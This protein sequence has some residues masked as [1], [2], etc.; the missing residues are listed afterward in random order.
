MISELS[1][2]TAD[3]RALAVALAALALCAVF[4]DFGKALF[5]GVTGLSSDGPLVWWIIA[6]LLAE[7]AVSLGWSRPPGSRAFLVQS[8]LALALAFLACAGIDAA[9]DR[10]GA[11]PPEA[12]PDPV[13]ATLG[14]LGIAIAVFALGLH[15]FWRAPAG[16]VFAAVCAFAALYLLAA[17]VQ[18]PSVAFAH[19]LIVPG[20]VA[21]AMLLLGGL[22]K[23]REGRGAERAAKVLA[24]VPILWTLPAVPAHACD[25][26]PAH[27]TIIG[28]DHTVQAYTGPGFDRIAFSLETMRPYSATC[29]EGEV[30]RLTT[31]SGGGED[32]YVRDADAIPL[33]P[34]GGHGHPGCRLLQRPLP[35]RMV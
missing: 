9:M 15:G 31:R 3:T 14:A 8:L 32:G 7:F 11:I 19:W 22:R 4:V 20:G 35:D 27:L 34:R 10:L 23:A 33:P 18:A 25:P 2:S 1:S 16:C 30:Y 17:L 28:R 29:K 6:A 26:V 13:Q 24:L 21:F 5:S 12:A